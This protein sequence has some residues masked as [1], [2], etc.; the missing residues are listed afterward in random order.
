M[1]I[2]CL[3]LVV[4]ALI[5]REPHSKK[6]CTCYFNFN[7]MYA[8]LIVLINIYV[9]MCFARFCGCVRCGLLHMCKCVCLCLCH[10]ICTQVCCTLILS[11]KHAL[12]II[13]CFSLLSSYVYAY[14]RFIVH[15]VTILM[16]VYSCICFF[17]M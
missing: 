3:D 17:V 12:F 7:F 4:Q 1:R 10:C 8:F 11:S 6:N 13:L 9:S 2:S 15:G 14:S 16:Y 5:K